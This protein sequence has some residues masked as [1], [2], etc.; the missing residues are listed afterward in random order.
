[1]IM[2]ALSIFK[3]LMSNSDYKKVR[4]SNFFDEQYYLLQ[5]PDIKANNLDA[6]RHFCEY[7]WKEL[8]KPNRNFDIEEFLIKYP[9]IQNTE[10]NPITYIIKTPN[11]DKD[12]LDSISSKDSLL[13]SNIIKDY[14]RDSIPLRTLR[15]ESEKTRINIYFNGFNK[16]CFFGG[17][18]TALLIAVKLSEKYGFDLRIIDKNPDKGIFYDFLKLFN[19]EFNQNVTFYSTK[20]PVYL[21]ISEKDHF[22]CTMWS[23]ADSVLR[24]KSITGRIFYIMQ[25]IETFFYDHGDYH[26]R[27]HTALTDDRLI[28]IVNSKLLYNY[29]SSN[30]Y[31]NVKQ[32]SYFEPAFSTDLLKPSET[33]F[34]KKDK[35]KLFYYA[36]PT[37]Q[38][39]LYYFGLD[40]LNSVFLNGFLNPEE[41][42]VY[43]AGDNS[44]S[45]ITFNSGLEVNNLGVMTWNEY[46]KFASTVD[47]C[48]SM[49]YT[50]HPSY[51]PFDMV[52]SGA[53]VVTNN[54]SNKQ[55]LENYSKNILSAPLIKDD[56]M[57]TLKN[58]S[59]LAKDSKLRESNYKS[60]N[61][62]NDWDSTLM[63]S[64]KLMNKY[65]VESD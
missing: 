63:K 4:K 45:N 35:Y 65:I 41:W 10:V 33:S 25:E 17:K 37:H 18:A 3:S 42:E 31:D 27:C 64:L 22:I 52:T 12:Y 1:M 43:F 53:V 9:E 24:T 55:G 7:G 16:G 28:P 2:K 38:R 47:L 59:D 29:F 8:R 54:Y 19:Q 44:F 51:V 58:G 61:I 6:A 34:K 5:N 46:C 49:I 30:G 32:G 40:V 56:M 21:E 36:R 62:E 20:L 57:Q 23:N 11:I 15:V 48:Y 50:P 60:S 26:L 39:N 14:F 13:V